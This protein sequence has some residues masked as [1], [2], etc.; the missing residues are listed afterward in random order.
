MFFIRRLE[1]SSAGGRFFRL[2]G[3]I[4]PSIPYD[5]VYIY[6]Q[7]GVRPKKYRFRSTKSYFYWDNKRWERFLRNNFGLGKYYAGYSG[8]FYVATFTIRRSRNK[9]KIKKKLKGTIIKLFLDQVN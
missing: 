5:Q 9:I 4:Y 7:K 8:G 1:D 6:H 3:L 2:R